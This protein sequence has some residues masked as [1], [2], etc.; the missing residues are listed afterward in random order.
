ME[1]GLAILQKIVPE[2]RKTDAGYS[3]D[4]EDRKSNHQQ[5]LGGYSQIAKH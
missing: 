5:E 1:L 3:R 2:R 4:A